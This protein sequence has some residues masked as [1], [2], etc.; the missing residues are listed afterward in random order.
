MKRKKSPTSSSTLP[1]EMIA[2]AVEHLRALAD[3]ARVRILLRLQAGECNVTCLVDELGIAQASVSKHLSILKRVGFVKMR[4]K[5]AQAL[6]SIKDDSVFTV[7][8]IVCDG[9]RRDQAELAV[10]IGL[11][12]PSDG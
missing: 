7:L 11:K 8:D 5:G 12:L 10:A 6:Y 1:P 2:K 4:R 3:D 9:V